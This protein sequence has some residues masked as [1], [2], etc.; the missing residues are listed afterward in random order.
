[1][2]PA[3]PSLASPP[4]GHHRVEIDFLKGTDPDACYVVRLKGSCLMPRYVDVD[5]VMCE[6]GGNLVEGEAV[7]I[8]PRPLAPSSEVAFSREG[9]GPQMKILVAEFDW[10]YRVRRTFPRRF[11]FAVPKWAVAAIDPV[12]GKVTRRVS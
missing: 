6:R 4:V 7:V 12:L 9:A 11:D 10:G 1:L 3:H 8:W 5:R 2:A